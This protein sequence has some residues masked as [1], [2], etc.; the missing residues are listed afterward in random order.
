M[1]ITAASHNATVASV[2]I[3]WLLTQPTITSAIIGASTVDQLTEIM[4]KEDIVLSKEEKR[5]LDQ[6]SEWTVDT[7]LKSAY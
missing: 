1:K 5:L 3:A 4:G 7:K 6:V 2:A